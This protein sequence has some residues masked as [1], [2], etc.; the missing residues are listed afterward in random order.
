M[1]EDLA[2]YATDVYR[3]RGINVRVN[4][5]VKSI[6]NGKIMLPD[7]EVIESETIIVAT[8]VLPSPLLKDID[9]PK[10][11][12]GR[13]DVEASM[14]VKGRDGVWGLGDCAAIPGPDGKPYPPL[15]Q[16]AIREA[17]VLAEN[18]VAQIGGKP[19][20]PFVYQSLGTLAALGS[21]QGVGRVMKLKLRGFPAWFVWRTYYL[22]Q[23]P[24]WS[25]RLRIMI[26]WAVALFFH[27]DVVELDLVH[28]RK[29]SKVEEE[30]L[31][32]R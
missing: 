3:K 24:R 11:R 9:L 30:K 15:A 22:F 2:N 12:K 28:D 1:D 13:I 16:H 29:I 23:M 18:I 21:F 14:R 4:T 10:D 20:K 5:P 6:D 27:Y 17:R 19:L 8:G 25:R 7:G 31:A 32:S 26:D